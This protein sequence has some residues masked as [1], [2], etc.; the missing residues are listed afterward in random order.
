MT[1]FEGMDDRSV[2]RALMRGDRASFKSGYTADNAVAA[3]MEQRPQTNLIISEYAR[4]YGAGLK[5]EPRP[6]HP[7]QAFISGHLDGVRE[8]ADGN[9]QPG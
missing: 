1:A 9:C 5:G 2:I 7:T 3:L 6:K 8:N 4:G